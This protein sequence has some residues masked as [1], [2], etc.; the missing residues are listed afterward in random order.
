MGHKSQPI[1]RDGASRLLRMRP[2]EEKSHE[3]TAP[4][5]ARTAAVER[6]PRQARPVAAVRQHARHAVLPRLRLGAVLGRRIQAPLRFAAR[7]DARAQ[8]RRRDRAGR[9]EP[10]ELRRRHDLADRPLGVARAV[11]LRAGAARWRADHD[12][13]DGRHPRRSGAP[14]CRGRGEGRAPQPQRPIR[15]GHGRA[16]A[17]TEAGEGPHRP[18]GDRSAPRRLHAGQPVQHAA[19]GTAGR[20]DSSSPRTSCTTSW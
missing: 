18:D 10:L 4:P 6:G 12:L 1:L 9:A 17:R 8:A 5:P 3:R 19:Q 20:R 15:A 2:R 16:A 14:A 11:L 13:F 7:Q